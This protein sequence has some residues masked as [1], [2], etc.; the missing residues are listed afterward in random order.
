MLYADAQLTT[1]QD[2]A[3]QLYSSEARALTTYFTR[4]ASPI[5]LHT[6]FQANRTNLC[7]KL[8]SLVAD[9]TR[10]CLRSV[11]PAA[12]SLLFTTL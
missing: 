5:M 12:Y 7:K 9:S 3:A 10:V 1:E 2:D 6:S 8:T 4:L 11:K